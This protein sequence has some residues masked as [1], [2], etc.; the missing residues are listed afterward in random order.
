MDL[1]RSLFRA[2]GTV[3][4]LAR[5]DGRCEAAGFRPAV[6]GVPAKGTTRVEEAHGLGAEPVAMGSF[7]DLWFGWPIGQHLVKEGGG[8]SE[9]SH[10]G[11]P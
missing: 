8:F 2:T 10:L 7:C 6:V 11:E 9:W 3:T 5:V 4:A 1:G